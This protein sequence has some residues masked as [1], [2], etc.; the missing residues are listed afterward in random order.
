MDL[1]ALGRFA[2]LPDDDL[3]L[4]ALLKTPLIGLDDDDLLAIAPN[5]GRLAV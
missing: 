3:T 2:L 1:I 4:A 5:R